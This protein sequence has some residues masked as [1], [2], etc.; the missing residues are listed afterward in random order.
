MSLAFKNQN[1]QRSEQ[2]Q[3][4]QSEFVYKRAFYAMKT[5]MKIDAT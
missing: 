3:K 1:I 2:R 4:I 5:M